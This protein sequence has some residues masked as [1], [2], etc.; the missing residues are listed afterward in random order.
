MKFGEIV[1][2][3][4]EQFPILSE[5][6][7]PTLFMNTGVVLIG[8][9]IDRLPEKT[10]RIFLEILPLWEDVNSMAKRRL[11]SREL[12]DEKKLQFFLDTERPNYIDLFGKAVTCVKEQFGSVLQSQIRL[13]TLVDFLNDCADN[14]YMRN[15]PWLWVD[16]FELKLALALYFDDKNM[17]ECVKREIERKKLNPHHFQVLYKKTYKEWQDEIFKK[18]SDREAF[19]SILQNNEHNRKIE[20]LNRAQIIVDEGFVYVSPQPK[21]WRR[22]LPKFWR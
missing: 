10:Y 14:F 15:L 16:L 3:W 11:I 6:T 12:V 5:W 20:K 21:G 18:F 4:R 17:M 7:K 1:D 22:F 19:L 2:S 8:L 13:S 9:R